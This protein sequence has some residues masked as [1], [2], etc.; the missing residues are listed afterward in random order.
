MTT[1]EKVGQ[2]ILKFKKDKISPEL[3]KPAA[4]LTGDLM[5]DSLDLAELLVL[6]EDAFKVDI[7][8]EDARKMK[9]L[10]EGAQYIDLRLAA[11]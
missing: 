8:M 7:P 3:L 4:T 6:L 2:I 5:L 9:T 10:G 11:S 1:L